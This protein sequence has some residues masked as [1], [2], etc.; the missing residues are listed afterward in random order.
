MITPTIG[1]LRGLQQIS[2]ARGMITVCAIDHRGSLK[3]A[4]EKANPDGANYQDIVDFKLDTCRVL[5][6][7][8][9]AVLLDPLYGAAEAIAAAALPGNIGLLVSV[10]KSG[11]TG[12]KTA[13][14]TELLPD[15]GVT[16]IKRMGASAVK[17][18]I[19]FRP[20][21]QEVASG[22]LDLVKR[23]AD[24][25]A[26]QDIALLVESLA[27]PAE[28][29]DDFPAR[30]PDI[31]AESARQ[32]T[33]L[34]I[35]VLK[36]EFPDDMEYEKDADRLLQHCKSLDA[37]SQRPWVLLSAGVDYD[38]FRD[39]VRYATRAGAS[40]FLAGR[41]LWQEAVQLPSREER[42]NFLETTALPRLREITKIAEDNGIPWYR[43]LGSQDG[44]FAPAG[45]GWYREY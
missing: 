16:K 3:R 30:K 39:Q 25:C 12:E 19:Y 45:E 33:A 36:A 23:V 10:E 22:Q 31:V 27:Y 34:P 26:Q 13:R 9:T 44:R 40:G 11:Y 24:E 8:A 37:A 7:L 6:Q 15:W 43:K 35:D 28:G 20:D 42:L 38:M 18:L 21:L 1:K 41:A 32:L 14:V 2:N 5:G 29:E 4:L 17:L